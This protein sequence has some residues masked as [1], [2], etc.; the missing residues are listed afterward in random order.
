MHISQLEIKNFRNFGDPSF[1]I[2]LTNT[3]LPRRMAS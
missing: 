2:A 1:V 3:S